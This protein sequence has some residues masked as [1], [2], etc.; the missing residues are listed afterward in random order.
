MP[1]PVSHPVLGAGAPPPP[2]ARAQSLGTSPLVRAV[3]TWTAPPTSLLRD[4]RPAWMVAPTSEESTCYQWPLGRGWCSGVKRRE[5][6]G[7]PP[8]H[9]GGELSHQNRLSG[10]AVEKGPLQAGALVPSA[11]ILVSA[12]LWVENARS[13]TSPLAWVRS[14]PSPPAWQL[15]WSCRGLWGG[16]QPSSRVCTDPE[17]WASVFPPPPATHPGV[18]P[19]CRCQQWNLVRGRAWSPKTGTV[20]GGLDALH[21]R[22]SLQ[23]PAVRDGQ[24]CVRVRA[25]GPPCV[26]ARRPPPL[27]LVSSTRC[28]STPAGPA[29]LQD[30]SISQVKR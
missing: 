29:A 7:Q 17:R 8:H 23:A 27:G 30:R 16:A 26:H 13:L 3:H 4:L 14:A 2:K 12:V 5:V 20:H 9:P 19:H 1:S 18:P 28:V 11:H 24:G 10:A 15:L 21:G 22:P 25:C 6:H